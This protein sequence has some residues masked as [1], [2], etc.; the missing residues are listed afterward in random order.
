MFDLIESGDYYADNMPQV[1]HNGYS[2]GNHILEGD[3]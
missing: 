1:H 2:S 3:E